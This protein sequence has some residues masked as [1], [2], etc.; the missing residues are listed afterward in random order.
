M[1]V[2]CRS[3]FL[4]MASRTITITTRSLHSEPDAGLSATG[5]AAARVALV[6]VLTREAWALARRE[7]P[8]YPRHA[9]PVVVRSLREA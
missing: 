8:A 5:T 1:T 6:E 3:I 7:V 9:S 4:I 2:R